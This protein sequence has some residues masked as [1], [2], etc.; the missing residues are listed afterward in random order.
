MNYHLS[1]LKLL[2]LYCDSPQ[3]LDIRSP[4]VVIHLH[5]NAAGVCHAG[6]ESAGRE[7][8]SSWLAERPLRVGEQGD[9]PVC[10]N[11][12]SVGDEKA[13]RVVAA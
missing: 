2:L 8:E 10:I 11:P 13:N 3:G 4:V 6:I 12:T 7:G 1:P 9:C 5:D